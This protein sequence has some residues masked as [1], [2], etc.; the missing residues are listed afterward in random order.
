[1]RAPWYP[2]QKP[3]YLSAET[4][5][6]VASLVAEDATDVV[7]QKQ[8]TA[9]RQQDAQ[10]AY[11]AERTA[12]HTTSRVRKYSYQTSPEITAALALPVKWEVDIQTGCLLAVGSREYDVPRR[13]NGD[14]FNHHLY[15]GEAAN[16]AEALAAIEHLFAT[17]F[18]N[19]E[20]G[21]AIT[22]FHVNKSFFRRQRALATSLPFQQNPAWA[23]DERERL[24]GDI[25]IAMK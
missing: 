10:L 7:A 3:T 23:E 5:E 18:A 8:R 22:Y 4:A 1:M 17:D 12:W 19:I 11:D 16:Y 2:N 13:N 15:G 6:Y 25:S 21:G 9:Q 24:T 20:Q 14:P